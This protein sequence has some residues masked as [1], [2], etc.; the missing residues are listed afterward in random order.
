MD[1]GF[2][3]RRRADGMRV[4]QQWL[5]PEMMKMAHIRA[6]ELEVPVSGLLAMFLAKEVLVEVLKERD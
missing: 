6:I 4:C 2:H 3:K 5:T 1:N